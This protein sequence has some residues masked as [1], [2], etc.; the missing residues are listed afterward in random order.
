MMQKTPQAVVDRR[1]SD[2]KALGAEALRAL[3]E[4]QGEEF[5]CGEDKLDITI[6]HTKDADNHVIQVRA[7]ETLAWGVAH[8]ILAE[9]GFVVGI[10]GGIRPLTEEE[11]Q[12]FD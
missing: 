6:H 8:R 12:K 3:P 2:L 10:D 11:W 4:Y 9:S 1:S 5:I 7:W